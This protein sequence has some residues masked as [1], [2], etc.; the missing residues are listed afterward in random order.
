MGI[1]IFDYAITPKL[2]D[3]DMPFPPFVYLRLQTFS[4]RKGFGDLLMTEQLMSDREID[5]S[6]TCLKRDLDRAA[7]RA[8][9]ALK[10]AKDDEAKWLDKRRANGN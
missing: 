5:E 9:K 8:K 6:V 7:M 10:R 2:K 4:N 3:D 1:N